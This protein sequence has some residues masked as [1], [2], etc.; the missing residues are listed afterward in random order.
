MKYT[1]FAELMD[2][3]CTLGNLRWAH[4][5]ILARGQPE[6]NQKENQVQQPRCARKKEGQKRKYQKKNQVQE[7]REEKKKIST[8]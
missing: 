6:R 7:K 2:F 5:P 1:I 8:Q 4:E 3:V